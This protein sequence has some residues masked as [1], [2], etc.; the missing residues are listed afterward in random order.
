MKH[1][2]CS[3]RKSSGHSVSLRVCILCWSS[4][5][6]KYNDGTGNT[7]IGRNAYV[8]TNSVTDEIILK[9]GTDTV[10]GGGTETIRIVEFRLH[11]KRLR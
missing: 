6:Y 4:R 10:T 11:N 3:S 8:S 2:V 5:W 9:A 1:H 7:V